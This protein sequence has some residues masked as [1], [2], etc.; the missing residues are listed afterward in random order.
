MKRGSRKKQTILGRESSTYKVRQCVRERISDIL[1]WA[2]K[3]LVIG[4]MTSAFSL[5]KYMDS[6][7][8]NQKGWDHMDWAIT[9]LR[10]NS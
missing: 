6:I 1:V 8:C 2:L 10:E 5:P 9:L 3:T 7:N 4:N